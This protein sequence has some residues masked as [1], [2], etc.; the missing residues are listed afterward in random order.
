MTQNEENMKDTQK[1]LLSM[2]NLSFSVFCI[3]LITL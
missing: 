3:L 2:G 1:G